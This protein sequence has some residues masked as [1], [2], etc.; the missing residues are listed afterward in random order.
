MTELSD[1]ELEEYEKL[2]S[3]IGKG[4]KEK[5]TIDLLHGLLHDN[6]AWIMV[7]AL[8]IMQVVMSCLTKV[9][10]SIEFVTP[11]TA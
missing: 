8:A 2:N 7:I 6:M 11:T 5:P 10:G 4:K 1:K 3:E 9:D